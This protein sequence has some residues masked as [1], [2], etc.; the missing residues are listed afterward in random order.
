MS[1]ERHGA[2]VIGASAGALDALSVI[3]PG[4]PTGFRL[5]VFVVVHVP[6]DKRSVLAE[7]FQAKCELEVCEAEDKESIKAG[8]VFFGPPGYHL[9]VESPQSLSLS[10]DDPIMFSRPSIDVLFETAA[11][12]YGSGLIAIVLTGANQDGAAGLKAVVEAGGTAVVQNP[13]DA[14]AKAMPEAAIGACPDA[15][16]MSLVAITEYL[17]KV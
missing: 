7:L 4:L 12:V 1:A 9:L 14:F 11:Q 6:P 5:P 2:V 17:K 8:T 15:K 16:I 13:H 3:L 10:T